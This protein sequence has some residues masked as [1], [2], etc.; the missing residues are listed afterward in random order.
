M[1]SGPTAADDAA[2]LAL[3]LREA[4]TTQGVSVEELAGR[5]GV[6]AS[7]IR[8]FEAGRVIPAR[9]PFAIYMRALG[10]TA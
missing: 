3:V 8:E 1:I 9:P 4:R 10:F 7:D 5:S 2:D 6:A